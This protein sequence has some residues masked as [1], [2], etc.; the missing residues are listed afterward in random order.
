MSAHRHTHAGPGFRSVDDHIATVAALFGP[1]RVITVPIADALGRALAIDVIA[2]VA[3][4]GFD[5]SA[6]DGYAVR[7]VDVVQATAAT[8]VRLPVAQDIPAGRT[9]VLTLLP[10]TAHRIMTGAP[11]P[12]GA[13][14]VVPVEATDAGTDTVTI[15]ESVPAGASV[16]RAGSDIEVGE[17]ALPAGTVVTPPAIGLLAALGH[18][19][20]EVIAPLHAVVLS[21]GS[22]LVAPG[23]PLAHGQIHES[24][25][26]ML[27]AALQSAG[28]MA[29]LVHFVPDDVEQFRTRLDAIIDGHA[30][31]TPVDLIITS[32]GVSAGAYEVVKDALTGHG[33][34][35]VK[36]A[37][38]PGKPQGSGHYTTVSGTSLP[39]VTLP[40]NPV[41]A[42][43]SFEV[44]VRGPLR[45]TMGLP[46]RR[47]RTLATLTDALHSP[48]GTRQFRRGVLRAGPA[49]PGRPGQHSDP[50]N[51]TATVV[52]I[53]PPSSHHLRYLA[54]SNALIDIPAD[55]VDLAAGDEVEVIVLDQP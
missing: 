48:A 17:P 46:A 27:C 35:F 11:L 15:R 43:V 5:N 52:P 2:A 28:A 16:R 31:S 30:A 42:Q 49:N 12:L 20:V 13:D 3:L 37:M 41:S 44:F 29:S 6:M 36:V 53:G 4:P 22:E 23:Q 14:A 47:R 24:N 45:A 51:H 50:D 8:S 34:D 32:G 21:T 33:V 9:D 39:I 19:Q 1:P 54:S 10:G 25:G 55:V 18:A 7:S 26:A 40:G 38:Q